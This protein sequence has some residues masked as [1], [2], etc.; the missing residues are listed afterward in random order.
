MRRPSKTRTRVRACTALTTYTRL[1]VCFSYNQATSNWREWTFKMISQ[2]QMGVLIAG[3][4]VESVTRMGDEGEV[5][6]VGYRA[7]RP[8]RRSDSSP[9]CLTQATMAV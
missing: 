9:S 8:I 7:V 6:I 5:R 4:D 2:R 3:G 1:V